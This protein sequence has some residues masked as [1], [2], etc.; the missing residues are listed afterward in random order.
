M[1]E[2]LPSGQLGEARRN[3][4][5]TRFWTVIDVREAVDLASEKR[6]PIEQ[7]ISE[8]VLHEFIHHQNPGITDEDLIVDMANTRFLRMFGIPGPET[9][10]Y[11]SDIHAEVPTC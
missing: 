8:I 7:V 11:D 2:D 5:N 1:F 10:D 6:A 4:S 9:D 3:E